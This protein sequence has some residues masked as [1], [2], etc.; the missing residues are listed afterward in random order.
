MIYSSDK[1]I[2]EFTEWCMEKYINYQTAKFY[3]SIVSN[4]RNELGI[5]T[6]D[7]SIRSGG[8]VRRIIDQY[9]MVAKYPY[10]S[11]K[12]CRSALYRYTE[13]LRKTD[14][15]RGVTNSVS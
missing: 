12:A 14:I 13:Y 6:V 5:T 11:Q 2:R 4:I 15:E 1:F 7:D 3:A 10:R 8:D 9:N